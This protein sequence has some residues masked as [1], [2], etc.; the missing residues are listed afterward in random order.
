MHNITPD[1]LIDLM[2]IVANR[3]WRVVNSTGWIRDSDDRCPICALANEIDA[4]VYW[5][6]A[7][8]AAMT[9]LCAE[10]F[11]ATESVANAA[12]R[13]NH[14]LRGKLMQALGMQA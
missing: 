7:A 3:G 8:H 13:H 5:S 1:T 11:D 12:D 9:L 6:L 14:A 2:P 10:V 4:N